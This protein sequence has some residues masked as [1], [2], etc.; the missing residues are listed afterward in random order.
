MGPVH[1][2]VLLSTIKALH[3]KT[4]PCVSLVGYGDVYL[5]NVVSSLMFLLHCKHTLEC[6]CLSSLAIHTYLMLCIHNATLSHVETIL[7]YLSWQ[8]ESS[9][10]HRSCKCLD[11]H[12]TY[13]CNRAILSQPKFPSYSI[14][15]C[16]GCESSCSTKNASEA[17]VLFSEP[18]VW[19]ASEL[20]LRHNT[21]RTSF[22]R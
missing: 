13:C 19:P 18:I 5:Q 2:L 9:T 6:L 17:S 4:F 20:V 8:Q 10:Q 3:C 21:M 22:L 14:Y 1:T 12:L 16:M 7:L 11:Q 15:T